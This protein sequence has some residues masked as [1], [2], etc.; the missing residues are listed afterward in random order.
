[1]IYADANIIIRLLEGDAAA[2]APIE[3]HLSPLRGSDRF[4]VTS[5]FT[6]LECRVKPLVSGDRELLSLYEAFFASPEVCLLEVTAGVI[7]K[8]TELR[9]R[10]GLSFPDAIHVAS[11]VAA[12]VTIFLTGDRALARLVDISVEAI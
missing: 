4:L 11:A 8:A 7:E 6:R 12:G 2:R 3:G 10:R 5:R 9:A 1:V